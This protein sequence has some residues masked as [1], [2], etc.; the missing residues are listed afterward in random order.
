MKMPILM[1]IQQFPHSWVT[2]F[3]HSL[4]VTG[5]LSTQ[6]AKWMTNCEKVNVS[7]GVSDIMDHLVDTPMM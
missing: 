2:V 7:A 3:N 1:P 5:P 6:Y 4:C